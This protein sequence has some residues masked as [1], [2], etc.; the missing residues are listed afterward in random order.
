VAFCRR[1][2]IASVTLT[3]WLAEFGASAPSSPRQAPRFVEA[4]VRRGPSSG[5][6]VALPSGA[7]IAVPAGFDADEL[8][9]I[10]GVLRAC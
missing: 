9:R 5:F 6:E 10:V 8:A 7:R 3:R 1:E 2:G 4:L